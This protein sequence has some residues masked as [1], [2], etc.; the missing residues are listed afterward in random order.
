MRWGAICERGSDRRRGCRLVG[1]EEQPGRDQVSVRLQLISLLFASVE[2]FYLLILYARFMDKVYLNLIRLLVQCFSWI[3][4][5]NASGFLS[6]V[7]M[8]LEP[9]RRI[10]KF[11]IKLVFEASYCL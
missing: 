4:L 11:W 2:Q 9:T 1:R 10:I 5:K 7:G 3:H 6:F 8:C